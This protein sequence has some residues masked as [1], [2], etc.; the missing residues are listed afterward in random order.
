LKF[1]IYPL[2]SIVSEDTK[3]PKSEL[4]SLLWWECQNIK[5]AHLSSVFIFMLIVTGLL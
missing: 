5:L 4:S 2:D 3:E 1:L